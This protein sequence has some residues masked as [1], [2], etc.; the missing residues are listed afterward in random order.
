MRR[1]GLPYGFRDIAGGLEKILD[2]LPGDQDF[3]QS[4]AGAK[5]APSD[6]PPD[7]F[8]AAVE[9]RRRLFHRVN[10]GD[11]AGRSCP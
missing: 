8:C 3:A 1:G 11:Q 9:D 10:Q 6:E 4:L 5:E 2:L 7:G